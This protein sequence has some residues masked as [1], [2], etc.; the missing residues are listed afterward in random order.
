[1][2][3][4]IRLESNLTYWNRWFLVGVGL[5]GLVVYLSLA[6]F[7]LPQI[8]SSMGDKVN[9]LLAYGVLMGWFGQLYRSW[10]HR[11]IIAVA[12]IFLGGGMEFVQGTTA[13]RYFEWL[14]AFANTMGVAGGLLALTMGADGI[15]RWFESRLN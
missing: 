7:H 2:S 15:L 1:V 13:H 12:L 6:G 5:I 3:L 14:D 8:P 11:F 9:H 10:R 4:S